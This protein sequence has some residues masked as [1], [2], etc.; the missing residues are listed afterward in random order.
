MTDVYWIKHDHPSRLAIVA[1]P[2]EGEWLVDDLLAMKSSGVDILV[3]LLEAHEAVYLGLRDEGKFAH[4]AG[5]EFISF[6]M[7]DRTTPENR[8]RFCELIQ[9][10]CEA[11]R[12]GKR[13]GVH[14]RGSIGRSTVTTASI[15]IESGWKAVDALR[16]IEEARGYPVPDTEE[17][18][19][20]ILQFTPSSRDR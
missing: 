4:L 1:R 14:C 17:Q 8:E 9:N 11:I 13:V 15:M 16:V 18:R 19:R 6:P 5:M 10:L 20:W 12:A 7:T 2:G 3:S